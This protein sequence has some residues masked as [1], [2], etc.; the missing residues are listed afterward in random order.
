MTVYLVLY[1]PEV[2]QLYLVT[3]FD[4]NMLLYRKIIYIEPFPG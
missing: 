1:I 3:L 2:Y 4:M